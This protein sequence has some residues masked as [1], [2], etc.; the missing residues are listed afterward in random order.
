MLT[1]FHNFT[2]SLSST[3]GLRK[4]RS[5]SGYGLIVIIHSYFH[6]IDEIIELE[7]GEY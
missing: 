7:F 3:A 4:Y 2:I 5:N 6:V 1:C